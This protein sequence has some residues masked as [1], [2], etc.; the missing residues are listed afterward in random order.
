MKIKVN[1]RE[2]ENIS[3]FVDEKTVELETDL[4]D[5][6]TLIGQIKNCWKGIDSE[7]FILNSTTYVKNT[8][9][10]VTELKNISNLIKTIAT[11]YG[12]KDTSFE[13]EIKKEGLTNEKYGN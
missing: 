13:K 5:V 1:Y 4:R 3:V 11:K 6:M 2:L 10:N 7:N 12:E 8:N 9:I